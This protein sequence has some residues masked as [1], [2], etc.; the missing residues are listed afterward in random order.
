MHWLLYSLIVSVVNCLLQ[1]LACN[2]DSGC[3]ARQFFYG[4]A[5]IAKTM[6]IMFI[7][8]CMF[9]RIIFLKCWVHARICTAPWCMCQR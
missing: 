7:F 4:D 3:F 8:I 9:A 5:K 6:L 2:L 1:L